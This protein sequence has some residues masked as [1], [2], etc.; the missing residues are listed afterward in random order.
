ML[1]KANNEGYYAIPEVPV[2]LVSTKW[3]ELLYSPS[4]DTPPPVTNE[5]L[6]EPVAFP[7]AHPLLLH[8]N[9]RIKQDL[10]EN[11]DYKLVSFEAWQL[12]QRT[13]GGM[14]VRRMTTREKQPIVEVWLVTANVLIVEERCVFHR[15][16]LQVSKGDSFNHLIDR[17]RTILTRYKIVP[18][19]YLSRSFSLYK[20]KELTERE[21]VAVLQDDS[22]PHIT[23]SQF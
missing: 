3:L 20:S 8:Y 16:E 21:V 13:Y 15:V 19:K 2:F 9:Y 7:I 12:L 4:H 17:L 6:L 5:L 22:K 10:R 14:E 1:G 23:H 11:E 18:E